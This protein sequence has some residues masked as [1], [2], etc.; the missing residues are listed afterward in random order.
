MA[1][2]R[3]IKRRIAAVAS[4]AKI[5]QAMRMVASAKLKR[6]Q[7][8]I[9]N[10]RPYSNRLN[11][12]LQFLI[13]SVSETYSHPLFEQREKIQNIC[14]ILITSDR[15]LCGSFNTNLIRFAKNYIENDI[16]TSFPFATLFM[17]RIGK[18][19]ISGFK[20]DLVNIIEDI[21]GISGRIDYYTIKNISEFV[22]N[23]YV[24]KKFD[25]IYFFYNEFINVLTQIPKVLK[26]LPFEPTQSQP[27]IDKKQILTNFIFEPNAQSILNNLLPRYIENQILRIMLESNAAE[28]AARRLAMENATNNAKDL[29]KHLELVYNKERQASI[30]KEMLDII[31]G[32]NA[33]KSA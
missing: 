18:R 32:T 17:I 3:D 4:T 33:L 1:T 19:G 27:A 2:L 20:S 30:T 15:G 11:S 22:I 13:S 5:T 7:E 26:I 12:N 16:H 23:S 8:A 10:A 21:S 9:H 6:A 25:K 29:I 31:G 28:H 24:Q 14:F